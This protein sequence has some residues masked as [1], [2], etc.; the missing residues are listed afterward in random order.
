[1]KIR[2]A[3][4]KRKTGYV[5]FD[6]FLLK[7]FS[8]DKEEFHPDMMLSCNECF[9]K[10]DIA[11]DSDS[12]LSFLVKF[13]A[14]VLGDPAAV[15]G[16]LKGFILPVDVTYEKDSSQ[17]KP[18]KSL[19]EQHYNL[20]FSSDTEVRRVAQDIF[21]NLTGLSVEHDLVD[22]DSY[23]L[24]VYGRGDWNNL[25]N[26]P[27]KSEWKKFIG[28]V[29][30]RKLRNVHGEVDKESDIKSAM[31]MDPTGFKSLI[32]EVLKYSNFSGPQM[33]LLQKHGAV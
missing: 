11:T 15:K 12:V 33:T 16:G 29:L 4:V 27:N 9:D 23:L 19:Q 22:I 30:K 3:K 26:L 13:K 6:D 5:N 10:E 25:I 2:S 24:S 20:L 1:M 8:K 28:A 7:E 17:P 21:N 18:F 31:N 14:D 32:G